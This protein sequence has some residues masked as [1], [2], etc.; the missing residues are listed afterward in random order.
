MGTCWKDDD[1]SNKFNLYNDM[2]ENILGFNYIFENLKMGQPSMKILDFGCGPGKVSERIAKINPKSKIIAV[3]QSNNMLEIAQRKHNKENISYKLIKENK[4]KEIEDE[5]MDCVVLCFVIINNGDK[6]NIKMI[7]EEIFR[8]LKKGGRFFILDSNPKAVGVEF[9]TFT[10]GIAGQTY[11]LGANKKQFLKIPNGED[12]VLED[13]YWTRDFYINNLEA[14][15]FENYKI[16][17]PTIDSI[18]KDNLNAIE[19]IYEIKEWGNE[20][21]IPPFIIFN[22][23]K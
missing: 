8:V 12:L 4:L 7:F 2:L 6:D 9:T 10:N 21:N 15:G 16:I 14:V 5:S 1:I 22:V 23:E 13:Y 17:E 20:K 18:N 3:D 19:K 11:P